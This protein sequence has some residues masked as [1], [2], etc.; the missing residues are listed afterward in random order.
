MEYPVDEKEAA[1]LD[2]I[3]DLLPASWVSSAANFIQKFFG[4]DP[5]HLLL[6]GNPYFMDVMDALNAYES[7][8]QLVLEKLTETTCN[9]EEKDH[10][11]GCVADIPNREDF[12][13]S[14]QGL[15]DNFNHVYGEN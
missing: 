14:P 2:F 11:C 7:S 13:K 3:K 12:A 8:R 5:N 15:L 6:V 1:F 4:L 10:V 9:C